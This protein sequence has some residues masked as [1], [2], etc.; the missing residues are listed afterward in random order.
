MRF[1]FCLFNYFPHGGLERNFLSIV[2]E[3]VQR[4]HQVSIYTRHWEGTMPSQIKVTQLPVSA[5]TNHSRDHKFAVEFAKQLKSESCDAIIGFNKMP[6]LDVYYAADPCYVAIAALKPWYYRLTP[7]YQHYSAYEAAV[8]GHRQKTHILAVSTTQIPRYQHYYQTTGERFSELPPGIN[9][10][11]KAPW[12][13]QKIRQA[14]RTEFGVGKDELVVLAIGADFKRKGL[15]RTIKA[16][17]SLP[18]CLRTKV[19]LFAVGDSHHKAYQKL[20]Q[21]LD[22]DLDKQL[23]LFSGRDDIPHFLFGADILAHPAHIENT[24]NIILEAIIAGLPV[25]A[26]DVCGY[27]FHIQQAQAGLVLKSPFNQKKYN[28]L[29][30]E[31]LTTPQR[32]DWKAN[33]IEYGN[34]KKLYQRAHVAADIIERI[35]VRKKI[36]G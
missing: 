17:A 14:W 10:N 28:R 9:P 16:I 5:L 30:L 4:G 3:C 2:E 13:H 22:L 33:G 32:A 24:G 25:L 31:I 35:A 21:Q 19:K 11:R 12:N 1:I 20:A 7:R 34:T 26:T 29:L 23:H 6:G 8:F 15:A 27:A 36:H 18:A